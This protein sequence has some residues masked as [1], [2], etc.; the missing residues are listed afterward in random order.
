MGGVGVGRGWGWG[1][2]TEETGAL[3]EKLFTFLVV[4][5]LME[6]DW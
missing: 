5:V 4:V 6:Q 1:S 2:V 3:G